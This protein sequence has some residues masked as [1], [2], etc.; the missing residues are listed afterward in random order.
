M[1][2][3]NNI[4]QLG[5]THQS[6]FFQAGFAYSTQKSLQ[7][8]GLVLDLTNGDGVTGI[9][10]GIKDIVKN[11]NDFLPIIINGKN[12]GTGQITS[13]SFSP[14]NDVRQKSY[15]ATIEIQEAGDLAQMVGSYYSGIRLEDFQYL[16]NFS[17]SYN[18]TKKTNG[19]YGY[20]HDASIQFSSGLGDL[21]SIQ[22]AQLLAKSLFEND[23][24]LGFAF[25]SGFTNKRGK[26]YITEAYNLIDN[27]CSFSESF[28]FDANSGAYSAIHNHAFQIDQNG[29]ITVSENTSIRG[30][31]N[32]NFQSALAALNTEK[33]LAYPRC[34]GVFAQY[35]PSGSY[36]LLPSPVSDGTRFDLFANN[37]EYTLTFNNN[38]SNSGLYFWTYSQQVNRQNGIA[39]VTENGEIRGRGANPQESF[40]NARTGYLFVNNEVNA[41]IQQ[42]YNENVGT[43]QIFLE[44]Q[45]ESYAPERATIS[46]QKDYSDE[47]FIVGESGIKR[48]LIRENQNIPIRAF[49]KY[50]ILNYKEI[51][52]DS[53]TASVGSKILSLT[54]I[55]EKPVPLSAYLS[56]ANQQINQRIPIGLNHYVSDASYSFNPNE[57]VVE[58]SVQWD[59]NKI[60][61]ATIQV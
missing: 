4:T 44:A 50:N 58:V 56:N 12:L 53:K 51:A 15:S 54:L 9:W 2:Q 52:Q 38:R 33:A 39:K 8:N 7:I 45:S 23:S 17:E 42:F 20:T 40:Q 43:N 61:S 26:R 31:E 11:A 13:I 19:G 27:S 28:D 57:N 25:Y 36:P 24:N 16:N 48:I 49:N 59:Y 47:P 14:G 22:S 35:A 21:N 46:Y 18:F 34:S 29:I 3:F 37:L 30:I 41:R 55:G 1:L 60:Q 6:R 32:P 5:V 10:T